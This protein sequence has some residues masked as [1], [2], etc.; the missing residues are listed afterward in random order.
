MEA[1]LLLL[2]YRPQKQRKKSQRKCYKSINDTQKSLLKT[3]HEVRMSSEYISLHKIKL[4]E[5]F[6]SEPDDD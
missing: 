4:Q 1:L 3:I 2:Q 6:S 5:R